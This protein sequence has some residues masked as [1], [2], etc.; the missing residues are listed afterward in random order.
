[1]VK[2]KAP[3][4]SPNAKSKILAL[5][6]GP[7]DK[8]TSWSQVSASAGACIFKCHLYL[9]ELINEGKVDIDA[10]EP[11]N[12]V[13]VQE[14]LNESLCVS[15]AMTVDE[16]VVKETPLANKLI[17]IGKDGLLGEDF[18][19]ASPMNILKQMESLCRSWKKQ[20]TDLMAE[21]AKLTQEVAN[22]QHVQKPIEQY[23]LS[24]Q[25]FDPNLD[26]IFLGDLP[27]VE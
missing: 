10:G 17:E 7:S 23:E 5:F 15:Y 12:F 26:D 18:K 19:S 2:R 11:W 8:P 1:M 27:E 9:K 22:L 6:T 4:E 3:A 16:K 14:I 13:P 21:N 24:Q 25:M 20:K